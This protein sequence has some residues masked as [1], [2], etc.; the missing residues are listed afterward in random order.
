MAG[1]LDSFSKEEIQELL[2]TS[3]TYGE[4]LEKVGLSVIANNFKTLKNYIELHNLS[5]ELIDK[6]R[7]NAM[8]HVK[9]DE[10]TFKKSLDNGTC[11]LK[12]RFILKKLIEYNIKQY[13]CEV[14]GI[15]EWNNQK[16]TLEI[17][18]KNGKHSD[19]H[20]DNLQ[21]LCPNC[22]SQTDNF[23]AKNV[24]KR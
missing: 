21:I 23:R 11:T 17:H 14:C 18:H 3:N 10:Q 22:H 4:V 6:N 20:L 1:K 19:N 2:N 5:T 8:K 16:I 12:P 24:S 15:S 13:K 7:I 9:Y